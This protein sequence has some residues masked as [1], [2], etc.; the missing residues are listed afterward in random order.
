MARRVAWQPC[1]PCLNTGYTT[2]LL[3]RLH[4]KL[5]AITLYIARTKYLGLELTY[6]QR[7][8]KNILL[9]DITIGIIKENSK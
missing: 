1:G 5:Y 9:F 2:P 4:Y 6:T 7:E 8:N 3:A